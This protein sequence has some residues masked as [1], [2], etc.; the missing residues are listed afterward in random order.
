M[1]E[2]WL[3]GLIVMGLAS[4]LLLVFSVVNNYRQGYQVRREPGV[5]KMMHSQIASIESG[6]PRSVIIG[7]QLLSRAYPGLGLHALTV[8]PTFLNPE[9][10]VDGGL[11]I[12]GSDGSMVA[13]ARQIVHGRYHG[14]FSIALHQLI[15]N[16][17][18]PGPTPF[19]FT[20]AILPMLSEQPH[21]LL[22]L[23]GNYDAEASLWAMETQIDG[24]HVFAA[25]GSLASQ[26]SLYLQVRD[27][28]IGEMVFLLP[29]LTDP[30]P[31]DRAAWLTEDILRTGLIITLIIAAILKMV[32]V[33]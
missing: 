12:A 24:G 21:R 9:T 28:L 13:F 15:L 18:L 20:A 1:N 22:A 26:A 14:E 6:N 2:M 32:G 29:G 8:L 30:S 19:S 16:T 31:S 23:F 17:T 4:I 10:A 5:E 3:A 25:A 33:I 11:T 7:H 27:L